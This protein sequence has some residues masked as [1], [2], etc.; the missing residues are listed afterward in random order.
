MRW[1][2]VLRNTKH[3]YTIPF[4]IKPE[5]STQPTGSINLSRF[6][7]VTLA[8]KLNPGN[9]ECQLHI[10]GIVHNLIH[11]QNG[12]LTFEFVNV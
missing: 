5:D 3:M 7:S 12:T 10:Y 6:D 8:L 11:I 2:Y 9:P 4:S 1:H